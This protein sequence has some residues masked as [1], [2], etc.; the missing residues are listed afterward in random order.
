MCRLCER[1]KACKTDTQD[2]HRLAAGSGCFLVERLY[3]VLRFC[4]ASL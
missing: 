1:E 3:G 4:G 2:R